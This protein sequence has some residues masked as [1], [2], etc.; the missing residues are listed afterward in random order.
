MAKDH[1]LFYK[2]GS[3][4]FI[5]DE[6][7]N[8]TIGIIKKSISMFTK[9]SLK[10]FDKHLFEKNHLSILVTIFFIILYE[11][12][13]KKNSVLD[14]LFNY[15]VNE[16]CQLL[17]NYKELEDSDSNDELYKY[18]RLLK[19]A[20]RENNFDDI[21]KR[22]NV[23]EFEFKSTG[24]IPTHKSEYPKTMFD[25][26]WVLKRPGFQVNTFYYNKVEKAL[27]LDRLKFY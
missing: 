14:D 19:R 21:D 16:L 1:I 13:T 18:Y 5:D 20:L 3:K 15:F 12:K 11:N 26:R 7:K 9:F 23:P 24:F 10:K 4:I 2:K 6:L 27:K 17:E 8:K 22:F 25:G